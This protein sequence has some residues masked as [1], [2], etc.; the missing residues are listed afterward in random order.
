MI[1]EHKP[2]LSKLQTLS[3]SFT[4]K[5]AKKTLAVLGSDEFWLNLSQLRALKLNRLKIQ[6]TDTENYSVNLKHLT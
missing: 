5:E 3:L 6:S 2:V 4:V 1:T